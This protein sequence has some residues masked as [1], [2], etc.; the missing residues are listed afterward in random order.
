M[1]KEKEKHNE[2]LTKEQEL[3][4]GGNI[5]NMLKAKEK[6]ENT[7]NTFT[8]EEHQE[9]NNII[10]LGEESLDTL[11]QANMRLVYDRAR[12]FKNRYPAAPELSDL[13]QEGMVGLM[14]AAYKYHPDRGNKFST[15]AYYW[16]IQAIGRGTNKTGRIVRLPENRIADFMKML[17]IAARYEEDNLS[18]GEIDEI[19]MNEMGLTRIEMMNIRNA[20]GR[21]ASLN[22]RISFEGG[23]SKE[24]IE[25]IGEKNTT[26]ASEDSVMK[27]EMTNI[28]NETLSKFDPMTR[29]IIASSFVID[30]ITDE[31]LSPIQVRKKYDITAG[32]Y[33]RILNN[34]LDEIKKTFD[35]LGVSF[36][37]FIDQ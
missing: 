15:V 18:Q 37:D 27:N 23:Q 32:K 4:L 35:N 7:E 36:T 3:A 20:E 9:L 22:K 5:Q 12:V 28:L 19:I 29:D 13:I 8:K 1:A 6:L 25:V 26:E 33:K 31:V 30:G 16:I 10:E 14:N 21:A 34:S 17:K 24:L 2:F 11:V